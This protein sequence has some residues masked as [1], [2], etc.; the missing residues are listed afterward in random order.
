ML[1]LS[2]AYSTLMNTHVIE[3]DIMLQ[4]EH[5]ILLIGIGLSADRLFYNCRKCECMFLAGATRDV[6]Y[7][8]YD[9]HTEIIAQSPPTD[10]QDSFH[11]HRHLTSRI[12]YYLIRWAIASTSRK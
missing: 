2:P 5:H 3:L 11:A 4:Y 1:S 6:A 10:T 8:A 12:G 9:I 7:R